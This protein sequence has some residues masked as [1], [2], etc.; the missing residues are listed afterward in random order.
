MKANWSGWQESQEPTSRSN[1][2]GYMGQ[3]TDQQNGKTKHAFG[4]YSSTGAWQWN[5]QGENCTINELMYGAASQYSPLLTQAGFSISFKLTAT[6]PSYFTPVDIAGISTS[7][8]QYGGLVPLVAIYQVNYPAYYA[9]TGQT[10]TGVT[11]G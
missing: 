11:V 5:D 7:P 9:A 3:P 2:D 6:A 8:F 4:N 10:G 1:Q